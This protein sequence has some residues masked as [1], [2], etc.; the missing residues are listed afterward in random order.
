M[1]N[2]ELA[3]VQELVVELS[4]GNPG[5]IHALAALVMARQEHILY[6]F[7]K[8]G[9]RGPRIYLLCSPNDGGVDLRNLTGDDV[10]EAGA[11]TTMLDELEAGGFPARM[12]RRDEWDYYGKAA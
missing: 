6:R 9:I 3:K 10:T 7:K 11:L 12:G 8:L 5:A 4:D 1:T 2:E